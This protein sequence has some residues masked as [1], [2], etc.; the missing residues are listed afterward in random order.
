MSVFIT[1]TLPS[2]LDNYMYAGSF[3]LDK[4]I[5]VLDMQIVIRFSFC[6]DRNKLEEKAQELIYQPKRE[7]E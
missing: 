5:K 4:G 1:G 6:F 3:C 7:N 2:I